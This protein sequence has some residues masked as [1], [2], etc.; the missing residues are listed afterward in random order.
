[1]GVFNPWPQHAG[2]E[3]QGVFI[4]LKKRDNTNQAFSV[5]GKVSD[6]MIKIIDLVATE[7]HGTAP[8]ARQG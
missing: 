7:S 4:W 8:A 5:T 1:M 2:G 6:I 3:V